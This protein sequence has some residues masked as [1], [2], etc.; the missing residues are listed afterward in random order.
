M[1][2]FHLHGVLHVTRI[3]SVDNLCFPIEWLR[4]V[5]EILIVAG[6]KLAF[7]LFC[8]F[9]YCEKVMDFGTSI[10]VVVFWKFVVWWLCGLYGLDQIV[11]SLRIN[12]LIWSLNGTA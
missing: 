4:C 7:L 8:S 6:F 5:V 9:L 3:M 2:S 12:S 1:L 10:G 11:E